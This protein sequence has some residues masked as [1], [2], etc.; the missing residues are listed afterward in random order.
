MYWS[1]KRAWR[2]TYK[3]Y[4]YSFCKSSQSESTV[5]YY[6]ELNNEHVQTAVLENAVKAGQLVM[7]LKLSEEDEGA[8]RKSVVDTSGALLVVPQVLFGLLRYDSLS[9][10]YFVSL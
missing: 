9:Y 5:R 3:T 1:R 7:K 8:R 10:L 2:E 6:V 4:V